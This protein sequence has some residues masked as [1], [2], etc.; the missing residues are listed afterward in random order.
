MTLR[1]LTEQADELEAVA[2]AEGISVSDAVRE[3]IA[4]HIARKRK[5]K[6]FRDRLLGPD[7]ARFYDPCASA[8]A[9]GLKISLHSDWNVT[10]I[11]PLRYV[12]N[13]VT[14]VM[15]EGGDVFFPEECI[16][17]DAALRAVTIDAAWQCHMEDQIGSLETGKFA[18]FAILEED[19]TAPGVKIGKIKVSETWMDGTKRYAA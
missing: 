2:R 18:D 9:A 10:P 1:L 15:N 11:E 13:A 4:E 17:V 14:R 7:R 8:L 12:E 16:P 19:P 3:A 5:D 6:A